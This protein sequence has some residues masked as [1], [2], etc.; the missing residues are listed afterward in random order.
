[1]KIEDNGIGFIYNNSQHNKGIGIKNIVSRVD[2]IKGKLNIQTGINKGTIL[3]FY[4]PFKKNQLI[5]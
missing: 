1:M 3:T 2:A 4:I 5:N